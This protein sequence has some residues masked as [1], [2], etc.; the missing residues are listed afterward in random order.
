ME[1]PRH[2][3]RIPS[4]VAGATLLVTVI[5]ACGGAEDSPVVDS[6]A[7]TTV[8]LTL[9][10]PPDTADLPVSTPPPPDTADLPTSTAAPSTTAAPVG[11]TPVTISVTV[12]V[13][14]GPD[15]VDTVP[16][17][18][19]VSITIV[20]PGSADEFHLHGYDL[21]D[22]QEIPAGQPATFTFTADTAGRFELESHE[23]HDVILVLEVV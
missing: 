7:T 15:R 14:A 9:P 10:P 18:S 11:P 17:G 5:A 20:N 6:A 12:G 21:G 1:T 22:G 2:R 3:R 4:L 13:D 23:T 19:L 8:Q 16:L